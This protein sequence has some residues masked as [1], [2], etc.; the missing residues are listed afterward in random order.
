MFDRY[1]QARQHWQQQRRECWQAVW[2]MMRAEPWRLVMLPISLA[3]ALL[4]EWALWRSGAHSP[5]FWWLT[6]FGVSAVMPGSM[7]LSL[8]VRARWERQPRREED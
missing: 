6:A 7:H 5:A 3:L 4:L 2:A 1:R 8:Y